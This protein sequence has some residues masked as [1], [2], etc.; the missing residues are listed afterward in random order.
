VRLVGID[1][2][3]EAKILRRKSMY[4]PKPMDTSAVVLPPELLELTEQIA[5][6]VHENWAKARID[7]G[8]R[9]GKERRAFRAGYG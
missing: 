4:I 7:E 2:A 5:E 9:Y 6:N 1:R 8:W 3:G